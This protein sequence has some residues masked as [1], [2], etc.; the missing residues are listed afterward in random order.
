MAKSRHRK[1][2]NLRRYFKPSQQA[3][4]ELTSILGPGTERRR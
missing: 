1:A 2:E 3:M 4:R